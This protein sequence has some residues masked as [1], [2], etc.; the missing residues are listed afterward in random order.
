[1]MSRFS[2]ICLLGFCVVNSAKAHEEEA[3]KFHEQI[4]GLHALVGTQMGVATDAELKRSTLGTPLKVY[5]LRLDHIQEF[6]KGADARK[7]LQETNEVVYPVHVD[8][9]VKSSLSFRNRDGKWENSS[10]GGGEILLT[11]PVRAKHATK[12]K[13]EHSQYF[14]VRAR[15]CHQVFVGYLEKEALF[16][17]PAHKHDHV[18]EFEVAE[19][20]P[21]EQAILLLQPHAEKFKNSLPEGEGRKQ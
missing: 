4:K 3:K 20:M 1:M 18:R 16:L 21:A 17:V 15:A 19:G 2:L 14:L 13:R 9:T 7:I 11:E 6:R 8:G 5:N 10:F 12:A